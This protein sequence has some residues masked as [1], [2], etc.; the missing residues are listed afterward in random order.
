MLN[1]L[2][3]IVIRNSPNLVS[4]CAFIKQ[5]LCK[6]G[7]KLKSKNFKPKAKKEFCHH[8]LFTIGTFRVAIG[9]PYFFKHRNDVLTELNTDLSSLWS[10]ISW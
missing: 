3:S 8:K 10:E 1:Q 5:L 4:F 2:P 9:N 7:R 6:N